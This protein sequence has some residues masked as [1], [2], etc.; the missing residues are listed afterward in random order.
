MT[1]A[2]VAAA[3]LPVGG[4]SLVAGLG[5]NRMMV[6]A[7]TTADLLLCAGVEL[8]DGLVVAPPTLLRR[9]VLPLPH[10]RGTPAPAT[11]ISRSS[12]GTAAGV[13]PTAPGL[14]TSSART[15]LSL[16]VP[17]VLPRTATGAVKLLVSATHAY[18]PR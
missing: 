2:P 12:V 5:L 10:L 3:A 18:C 14:S 13:A 17:L 7:A 8:I 4:P 15:L 11:A 1:P 6:P 9:I 16:S